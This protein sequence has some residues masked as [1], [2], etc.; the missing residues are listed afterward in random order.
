M[1]AIGKPNLPI[2]ST[3]IQPGNG[4]TNV[5]PHDNPNRLG[6]RHQTSVYETD[7]DYGSDRAGLNQHGHESPNANRHEPIIGHGADHPPQAIAGNRLDALGQIFH[8][9]QENTQTT[10]NGQD[11]MPVIRLP[12]LDVKSCIDIGARLRVGGSEQYPR[13]SFPCVCP[14]PAS[15][16]RR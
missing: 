7:G 9:Q 5:R 10:D 16:H 8:A 4:G 11:H 1:P 12:E 3:R 14:I 15:V 6:Q 2:L 13:V